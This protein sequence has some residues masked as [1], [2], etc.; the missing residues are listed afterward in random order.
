MIPGIGILAAA[1][2]GLLLILNR[3]SIA[4]LQSLTAGGRL[5]PGCVAAQGVF[6]LLIA[7]VAA[8]ALLAGWIE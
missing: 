2:A 3:E 4:H 7:A 1:I 8:L 5:T 6:F